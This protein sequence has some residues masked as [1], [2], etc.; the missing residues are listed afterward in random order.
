[1]G[2]I[3]ALI[4]VSGLALALC[5]PAIAQEEE[6]FTAWA[7]NLSNIGP[8][9]NSQMDITISRWSSDTERERL[10]KA[11]MEKGQDELLKQLQKIKPPVGRI[12]IPGQIGWD[13]QFA[14]DLKGED[15]GRRIILVT[16]RRM[17]FREVN[18]RSR[19]ID[20]PFT[21]IELHL[22][23][24]GEGEGRA[25]VATKITLNKEKNV[26]ELENYSSQPVMLKN[27]KKVK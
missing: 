3:T 13:L 24:N 17:S 11:F 27:V 19:T 1:M 20:Y 15:G 16:D 21:L 12:N 26:L 5:A 25:S 10:I 4:A 8:G 18:N 2:R 23:Q 6:R 22:D 9:T 14:R 7:V